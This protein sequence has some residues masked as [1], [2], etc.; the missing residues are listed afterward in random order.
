M[1]E[2]LG[3]AVTYHYVRNVERTAFPAIRAL[4][5]QDFERQLDFLQEHFDI[6]THDGLVSALGEGRLLRRPFALL[7]FDDGFVDH[8]ETVAPILERRGVRGLFFVVGAAVRR[9]ARLLTVHRAHFLLARLGPDVLRERL[10]ACLS[11][12]TTEM[13]R[14]GIYRYDGAADV[15]L[16]RVL[17]YDLPYP[18]ADRALKELFESEIGD[19]SAFADEL[20]MQMSHLQR[21]ADAGHAVGWHT[22]SHPVMSRLTADQQR[23]E[24]EGGMSQL[25]TV[26]PKAGLSFCYPYGHDHTYNGHTLDALQ[27]YGYR[28][29]F[30]VR[31]GALM[32]GHATQRWPYELP[33]VDCRDLP[34]FTTRVAVMEQRE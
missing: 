20:Y 34:P 15:W 26:L 27:A 3:I 31:R 18:V 28:M 11:E 14:E 21:M 4:S 9:P 1:R 2:I 30:T 6:I 16:K 8:F 17:T 23:R 13:P 24:L 5:V 32:S 19:M 22:E 29:A 33:R 12:I 7:T 10:A 25:E